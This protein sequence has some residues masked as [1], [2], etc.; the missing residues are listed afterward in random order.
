MPTAPAAPTTYAARDRLGRPIAKLGKGA[1][2]AVRLHADCEG[3]PVAVK[4]YGHADMEQNACVKQHLMNEN[5]ISARHLD[6]EH[7]IA[8]QTVV[9]RQGRTEVQMEYAPGGNLGEYARR[10]NGLSESEARRLFRQIVDAVGY[11][12]A[13]VLPQ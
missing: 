5:A 1:Y 11:L 9:R 2:S 8:P 13:K 7:I 6:H 4:S 12:H 10:K 3:R